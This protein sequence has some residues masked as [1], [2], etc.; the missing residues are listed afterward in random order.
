MV[1]D[2]RKCQRNEKPNP[3]NLENV[4]D[5]NFETQGEFRDQWAS[6]KGVFKLQAEMIRS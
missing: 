3:P 5:K 1:L 2:S 6:T 4:K